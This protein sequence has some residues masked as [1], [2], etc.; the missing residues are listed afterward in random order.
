MV[1]YYLDYFESLPT[2]AKELLF[3][4]EAIT[5]DIMFYIEEEGQNIK[6]PIEIVLFTALYIFKLKNK[7][8]F[9]LE[10]Q[11]E[12]KIDNKK[13]IADFYIEYDKLLNFFLKKDFKLI[14]ECDGFEYH[15]NN[16]EQV[17]YDYE[18]EN[19]LKLNGYDIIRFTGSQI[20]NDPMKCVYQIISYIKSKGVK[21]KK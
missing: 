15:H 12:I 19:N 20:Y 6:S 18:R 17:N 9:F 16:K 1:K 2:R 5:E 8:N 11:K 10:T 4:E 13:Y 21:K 3:E 14:I 7:L